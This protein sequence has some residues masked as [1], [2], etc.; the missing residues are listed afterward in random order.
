M[1]ED[2]ERQVTITEYM[3]VLYRGRWIIV[4]S[5]LVVMAATIYL[6]ITT[7]PVYEAVAKLM[8]EEE[9][10]MSQSLFEVTS[11][12]KREKMINNQVEILKSRTL[13]EQVI[14]ICPG[15]S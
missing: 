15:N 13:A 10:G 12:I 2:T 14:K 3:R 9:G 7:E 4:I 6:T 11:Y 1:Q 8:I 5:F